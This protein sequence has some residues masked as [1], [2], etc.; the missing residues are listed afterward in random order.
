MAKLMTVDIPDPAFCTGGPTHPPTHTQLH[1]T[2]HAQPCP[3]TRRE[4]RGLKDSLL[5]ERDRMARM[6]QFDSERLR[7]LNV[8]L[9][10]SAG[11]LVLLS[12]LRRLP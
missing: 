8:E 5:G 6:Q 9:Q 3:P 7:H 11:V 2:A 12:I 10:A 4:I 1:I